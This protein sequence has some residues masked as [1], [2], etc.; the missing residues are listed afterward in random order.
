M[1]SGRKLNS[2]K[3]SCMSLSSARM[4]MI[5]SKIKG[6]EGSH[7]FSYYKSMEAQVQLTLQS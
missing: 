5:Q 4:K 6:I 2:S 7:H 1:V 3:Y